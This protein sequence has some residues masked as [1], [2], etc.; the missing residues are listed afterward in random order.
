LLLIIKPNAPSTRVAL[1]C[2]RRWLKEIDDSLK[3]TTS[4]ELLESDEALGTSMLQ[5]ESQDTD[6][7]VLESENRWFL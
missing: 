3:E 2:I 4:E 5:K 1:N 7:A 6:V